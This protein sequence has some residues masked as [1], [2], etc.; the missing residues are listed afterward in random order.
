MINQTFKQEKN[1][2]LTIEKLSSKQT[3][4]NL[5]SFLGGPETKMNTFQYS[6]HQYCHKHY[7]DIIRTT[8]LRQINPLPIQYY[9][10]KWGRNIYICVHTYM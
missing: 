5:L 1:F 2:F 7:C 4:M 8:D 3:M 6:V 10:I 9:L